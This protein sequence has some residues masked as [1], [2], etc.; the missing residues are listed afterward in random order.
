MFNIENGSYL[1][2]FAQNRIHSSSFVLRRIFISAP[3]DLPNRTLLATHTQSFAG[4]TGAVPRISHKDNR[5]K[6]RLRFGCVKRISLRFQQLPHWDFSV[7]PPI[8]P[9]YLACVCHC[10]GWAS[11][12]G[13]KC[14][15][16]LQPGFSVTSPCVSPRKLW[17]FDRIFNQFIQ[18]PRTG[19]WKSNL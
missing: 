12:L 4:N 7:L 15:F 8:C 9:L 16:L 14:V 11:H 10:H 19:S 1:N 6:D 3:R 13:S 5:W 18:M 17:A 2:C